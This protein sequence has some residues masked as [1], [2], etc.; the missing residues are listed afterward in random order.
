MEEGRLVGLTSV[1]GAFE[2]QDPLDECLS[3]SSWG[4][5]I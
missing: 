5:V 2:F 3:M 4:I 1:A